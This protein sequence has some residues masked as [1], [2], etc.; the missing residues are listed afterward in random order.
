M[1]NVF[2]KQKCPQ[3]ICYTQTLCPTIQWLLHKATEDFLVVD[4][5]YLL[6]IRG[7][8]LND[9]LTLV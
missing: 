5:N 1:H 2:T 6:A 9:G 4:E 7:D 3:E 8:I